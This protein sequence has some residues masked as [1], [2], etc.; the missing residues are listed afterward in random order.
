MECL[1][2]LVLGKKLLLNLS[3]QVVV[4]VSNNV[5]INNSS[6]VGQVVGQ[7]GGFVVV[8]CQIVDPVRSIGTGFAWVGRIA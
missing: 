4:I 2:T 8:N 7:E 3:F 1:V 5:S 6:T